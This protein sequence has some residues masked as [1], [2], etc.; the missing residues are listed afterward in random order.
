MSI[1]CSR[2]LDPN[3]PPVISRSCSLAVSL[4][5]ESASITFSILSMEEVLW[6][7]MVFSMSIG[8]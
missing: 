4:A 6:P 7:S 5:H 8:I 2:I 3:Y 1:T